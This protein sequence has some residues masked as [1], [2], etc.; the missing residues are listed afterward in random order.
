MSVSSGDIL[1]DSLD[2]FSWWTRDRQFDV[3]YANWF[4]F[5]TD[6]NVKCLHR[7]QLVCVCVCVCVCV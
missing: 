6:V 7:Y 2:V 1:A 3:H 5:I 4:A